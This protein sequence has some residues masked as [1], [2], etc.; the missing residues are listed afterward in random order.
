MEIR[1]DGR[2]HSLAYRCRMTQMEMLP[3]PHAKHIPLQIPQMIQCVHLLIEAVVCAVGGLT[4]IFVLTY[5]ER[6]AILQLQRHNSSVRS[7]ARLTDMSFDLP[8]S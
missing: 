6:S 3:P 7:S 1:L 8:S 5:L 4:L 2:T